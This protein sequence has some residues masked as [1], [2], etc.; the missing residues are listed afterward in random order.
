[1]SQTS[2]NNKRVAK[3]PIASLLPYAPNSGRDFV[4]KQSRS[5]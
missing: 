4:Y 1:M 3:N 5:I 2:D